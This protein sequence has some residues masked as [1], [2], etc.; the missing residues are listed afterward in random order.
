MI[1]DTAALAHSLTRRGSKQSYLTARLLVDRKLVDDCCRAYG[2]FRWVDDMVDETAQTHGE[3]VSF[4]TRQRKLIAQLYRGEQPGSLVPEEEII[5]DLI[6]HDPAE[7]SRLRSFVLNFLAI[8]EFDAH[9]RGRPISQQELTWYSSCLG[10]AV[11]DAIQHFIGN[12]H[13]YPSANNQYSAATAA[14]IAHMLRDMVEDTAE[15]YVN[16]PREYME[17]HGISPEDVDSLA[18]RDWVRARVALARQLIC[19]GKDYIDGLDV[20][21][22]KIAAYWYCAR[23]E[24]VLDAIEMDG[25]LLRPRY[26]K[27]PRLPT[28]LRMAGL[29]ISLSLRHSVQKEEHLARQSGKRR[30]KPDKTD[31]APLGDAS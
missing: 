22:C 28:W 2:Y 26:E 1:R 17:A 6:G 8:I 23:F 27:P 21:R 16:I 18:F 20:L 4:I 14:H 25:Y 31:P 5:A 10:K 30:G 19:E 29:A 12:G 9:R 3:R 24:G 11:T 7:D 15:G 13:P